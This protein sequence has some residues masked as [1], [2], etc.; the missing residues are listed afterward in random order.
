MI[1]VRLEQTREGLLR[2][3]VQG[4]AGAAPRGRDLICGAV[5]TLVYTLA[6]ALSWQRPQLQS[7]PEI[8]IREGA[9]MIEALPKPEGR[10]EVMHTFW[11]VQT[12]LRMLANNYPKCIVMEQ[13]LD[14]GRK[15]K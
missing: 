6:Q 7:P 13:T 5:T 10:A 8:R 14:Q 1:T 9:A 4:H 15:E 11:V 2:M 3:S 12:G